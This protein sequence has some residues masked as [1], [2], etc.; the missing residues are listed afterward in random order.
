MRSKRSWG[1]SMMSSGSGSETSSVAGPVMSWVTSWSRDSDA[2]PPGSRDES[3]EGSRSRVVMG[4]GGGSRDEKSGGSEL[5][6]NIEGALNAWV[7]WVREGLEG[8]K[9]EA[10]GCRCLKG[11]SMEGFGVDRAVI[12]HSPQKHGLSLMETHAQILGCHLI[13]T[14]ILESEAADV[15]VRLVRVP[16]RARMIPVMVGGWRRRRKGVVDVWGRTSDY[17]HHR[18]H[19]ITDWVFC[20]EG[21]FLVG[22]GQSCRRM[23]GMGWKWGATVGFWVIGGS[24]AGQV[25]GLG[26]LLAGQTLCRFTPAAGEEAFRFEFSGRW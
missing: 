14:L 1:S 17:F 20:G 10:G 12:A 26:R 18:P 5:G 13:A 15:L 9:D 6:R 7:K 25:R 16:L 8:G 4:S 24:G 21:S 2:S 11:E 19:R 3:R 23:R 22:R